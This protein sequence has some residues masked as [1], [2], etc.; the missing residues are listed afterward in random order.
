[1]CKITEKIEVQTASLQKKIQAL[2]GNYLTNTWKRQQE[3]KYR[4][5][6]IENYRLQKQVLEYLG[7]EANCRELSEFEKALLTGCFYEDMRSLWARRKYEQEHSTS[8][9]LQFPTQDGTMAKRLR[10]AGIQN[11]EEMFAA[12]AQFDELV[13]CATIPENPKVARIRDI[14]YQA[15]LQQGGDIQF[16]PQPLVKQLIQLGEIQEDSRVLEPEAGIGYIADELRQIT[17]HVD[18]IEIRSS[19]RELLELKGHNLVGHDLLECEPQPAYDAVL[20]NPPFSED[21]RHI[22]HAFDFLKP[23]G[24]LVTVCL[25]RIQHSDQK[26]YQE[27]REWLLL[28]RFC[29]EETDE[30]FEMTGAHVKLLQIKKAA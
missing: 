19:F 24:R 6:Q 21:S 27:F 4:D 5:K 20:M 29:F 9:P 13:Y 1:M 23:G 11:T 17:P 16:T 25:D 12:L 3:Q 26:K 10:K 15:R 8:Y 14:T 30:K 2:S 7:E 22:R 28:H 18:C